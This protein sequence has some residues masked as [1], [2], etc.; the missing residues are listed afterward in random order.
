MA[1]MTRTYIHV[2]SKLSETLLPQNSQKRLSSGIS[3]L[4]NTHF[5][6]SEFIYNAQPHFLQNL[7]FAD[8]FEPHFL[9]NLKDIGGSTLSG[10][11]AGV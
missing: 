4:Q 3:L 8:I 7:A 6:S 1:T 5:I 9:Q 2:L 11:P 10:S